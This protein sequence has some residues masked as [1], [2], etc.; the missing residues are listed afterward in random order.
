MLC[1]TIICS[2]IIRSVLRWNSLFWSVLFWLRFHTTVSEI[3]ALRFSHRIETVTWKHLSLWNGVIFTPCSD[4]YFKLY[5]TYGN[6]FM[7]AYLQL[8]SYVCSFLA[9]VSMF[10]SFENM[11]FISK[12]CVLW[13]DSIIAIY[14]LVAIAIYSAWN[15]YFNLWNRYCSNF[16]LCL[17]NA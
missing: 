14:E 6:T 4:F 8:W 5:P 13:T 12:L 7:K 2:F 15:R 11:L 9:D 1:S 10:K 16:N 3:G 17:P